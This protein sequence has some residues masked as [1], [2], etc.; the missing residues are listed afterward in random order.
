[1][2]QGPVLSFCSTCMNR[3][4]QLK[5]TLMHN[6]EVLAKF[7]GKVELCLVNF[8]KDSEG[9]N[10]HRWVVGLGPRVGFRYAVSTALQN[11]HAP[12]AKNTS[13]RLGKGEFLVNLDCDNFISPAAVEALL[14]TPSVKLSRTVFSAFSGGFKEVKVNNGSYLRRM[15]VGYLRS[16]NARNTRLKVGV[17]PKSRRVVLRSIRKNPDGDFNGTYGHIG[18]PS[19]AFHALGGYDESFPPMGAQD[20]DLLW[21]TYNL[22]GMELLHIP[23]PKDLMP[24][25]NSKE[26]SLL[27][28]SDRTVSWSL[29]QEEATMRALNA[30]KKSLLVVNNGRVMGCPFSIVEGE[31]VD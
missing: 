9:E 14:S 10:I 20:K 21:R 27:H 12:I 22:G 30:I 6:L 1:M 31:R 28:A 4:E 8:I 3:G 16:V 11:W 19:W 17:G 15:A 2:N 26:A 18:L 23:Q 24:V 5:Q 7:E 29:M 13:H 25:L